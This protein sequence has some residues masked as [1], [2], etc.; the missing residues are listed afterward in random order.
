M[1]SEDASKL[2]PAELRDIADALDYGDYSDAPLRARICREAAA[3]IERL[4]AERDDAVQALLAAAIQSNTRVAM[5]IISA[6]Y[7]RR[8]EANEQ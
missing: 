6:W 2:L 3:E 8:Q 7:E 5:D 1:S 4:R